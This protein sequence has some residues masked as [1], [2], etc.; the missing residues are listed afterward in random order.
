MVP[1]R[2]TSWFATLPFLPGPPVAP[3]EPAR[4]RV[5]SFSYKGAN[6]I[7]GSPLVILSTPSQLPKG[8]PPST[9]PWGVRASTCELGDTNIQS[10]TQIRAE[11]LWFVQRWRS[12]CSASLLCS[13]VLTCL[14]NQLCGSSSFPKMILCKSKTSS[15]DII[16]SGCMVGHCTSVSGSPS[17]DI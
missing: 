3:S 4:S 11:L 1:G 8:P 9:I 2:A 17:S 13:L 12:Q 10:V 14:L 5:S 15:S 7:L 16:L 6:P